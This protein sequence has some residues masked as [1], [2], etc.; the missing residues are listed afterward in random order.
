[1]WPNEC[2]MNISFAFCTGKHR[3]KEVG[4][5]P[6]PK[7]EIN[8]RG[9]LEMAVITC[10]QIWKRFQAI[11]HFKLQHQSRNEE[12]QKWASRVATCKQSWKFLVSRTESLLGLF[13]LLGRD[14]LQRF[15][16]NHRK[17]VAKHR[18]DIQYA[19]HQRLW[20]LKKLLVDQP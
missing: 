6:N 13:N 4:R 15:N 1:M 2:N 7:E 16:V 5:N 20:T 10:N 18:N 3:A 19:P 14:Y 9:S 8:Q 12:K 17:H 11:T